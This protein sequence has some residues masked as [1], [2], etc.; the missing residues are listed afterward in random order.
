MLHNHRKGEARRDKDAG[1]RT[2][3]RHR[4]RE[5]GHAPKKKKGGA[6]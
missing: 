4:R 1:R 2:P 3:K 5:L 6:K